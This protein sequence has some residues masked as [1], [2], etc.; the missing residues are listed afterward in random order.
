MVE[1]K[2]AVCGRCGKPLSGGDSNPS[3]HRV[4][5]IP[6]LPPMVMEHRFHS[7]RCVYGELTTARSS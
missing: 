2:P 3:R 5:G 4:W 7:L 1:H 6:P